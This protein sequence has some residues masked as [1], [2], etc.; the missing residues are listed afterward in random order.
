[1]RIAYAQIEPRLGD[2]DAN[3][4]M[5][6]RAVA[7]AAGADLVVLPELAS[8]GYNFADEAQAA[9]TAEESDG[10]T[11]AVLTAACREHGVHAVCGLNEREGGQR[12]NS[13]VVVGPEGLLGVYRKMHLFAREKLFFHPGNL[14]FPTFAVGE[15]RVGVLICFDWAFPEC[16][17]SLMLAGADV[18]AHPSNLVL[19]GKGQRAVPVLAMMHRLYAVLANRIGVERDLRFTGGSLIAGPNGE[20]LASAPEAA[21]HV[22]AVPIDLAPARDKKLTETN[23]LLDDRRPEIFAALAEAVEKG[24]R[25]AG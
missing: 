20:V 14:G 3:R 8:S 13:A 11:T 22:A 24:A 9:A 2:L 7:E 17:T 25:R 1:M 16:W 10:E 15:A 21:E 6:R 4:E 12:Y 5:L 18:V 23:H 19:P